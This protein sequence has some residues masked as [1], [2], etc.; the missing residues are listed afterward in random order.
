MVVTETVPELEPERM[1]L[2]LQ[3]LADLVQLLPGIRERLDAYPGKPI[4]TPVHQLADIA[5]RDRLPFTVHQHGFPAGIVPAALGFAD[6]VG[7]VADVEILLAELD[8]LEQT[9]HRN[10]CS[11]AGL[12]DGADTRWKAAD[13]GY[14]VIDLDAGL[15][16]IGSGKH[17]LHI[18]IE[19]LNERAFVQNSDRLRL[20]VR[21]P[22]PT[23]RGGGA[24]RGKLQ[25]SS[26]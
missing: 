24:S 25:K 9:I 22:R 4:G 26:T 2:G 14:L 17:I 3:L 19:W 12:G 18:V 1:V 8:H 10:I 15:L 20:G 11:R 7:D 16:L 5:E 23:E 13:A 6:V 21:R